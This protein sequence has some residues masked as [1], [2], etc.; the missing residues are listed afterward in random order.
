MSIGRPE[1]RLTGSVYSVYSTFLKCRLLSI[2]GEWME[3]GR[4]GASDPCPCLART[5]KYISGVAKQF[6]NQNSFEYKG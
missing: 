1:E 2:F 3:V 6:T 4:H 5:K